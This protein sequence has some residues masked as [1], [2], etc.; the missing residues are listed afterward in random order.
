M[1]ALGGMEA[2]RLGS[3]EKKLPGFDVGQV[4]NLP[5]SAEHFPLG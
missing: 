2:F 4:A 3:A 1:T 5:Q